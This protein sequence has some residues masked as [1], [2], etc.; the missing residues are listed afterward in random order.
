MKNT[1]ALASEFLLTDPTALQM[2]LRERWLAHAIGRS[3]RKAYPGRDW[4]VRVDIAGQVASIHCPHIHTQWG[5]MI[6]LDQ[7]LHIIQKK[8][9]HYGGELLERFRL[10]RSRVLLGD[11]DALPRTAL[12]FVDHVARGGF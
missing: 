2:A 4:L 10:S 5:C 11:M 3:L 6:H 9:V 8:A 12:G 1:C 7:C